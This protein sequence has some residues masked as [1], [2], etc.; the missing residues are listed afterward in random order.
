[1]IEHNLP[2][3]LLLLIVGILFWRRRETAKQPRPGF[4]NRITQQDITARFISAIPELTKESNLEIASTRQIEVL[5]RK[6]D[7]QLLGVDLGTN[8]VQL[9]VPV[10]YRYN[11]RLYDPWELQIQGTT[12]HV[13]SPAIQCSLPPAIFTDQIEQHC[14]RGW[15]RLPPTASLERLHRDVTP[16]LTAYATDPRRMEF[17]R[18]TC[19][20]VVAEFVKK[21]LVGEG[22]WG[23]EGFTAITIQFADESIS[24]SRATLQ[25]DF[26]QTKMT[27][28]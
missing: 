11:I 20:V 17:V 7:R 18:E 12:L 19:R 14:V 3:I 16:T 1:L 6:D 26:D 9:K 21:W 28:R 4:R 25:L 23:A 13:R 24:P 8:I 15:A 27:W 2:V 10:V 5:E 22:T